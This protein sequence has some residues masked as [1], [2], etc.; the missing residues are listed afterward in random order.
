M[1]WLGKVKNGAKNAGLAVLATMISVEAFS[2]IVVEAGLIHA[3]APSYQ[4][5][6]FTPFRADINPD[7]GLWRYPNATLGHAASCFNVTYQSNSYGARDVERT[8]KADGPRTVVLGDSFVEGIGLNREDRFTEGLERRTGMPHLNFGIV[9]TGPTHYWLTYKH[10]AR[11]FDHDRVIVGILPNN[12]FRDDDFEA[13]KAMTDRYRP[14]FVKD[15]GGG[16]ELIYFDKAN[17]GTGGN[18]EKTRRKTRLRAMR[19]IVTNYSYAKNVWNYFSGLMEQGALGLRDLRGEIRSVN[20][21]RP[22]SGFYDYDAQHL[23]RMLYVLGRIVEDAQGRPVHFVTI[24]LQ[25]DIRRF[26]KEGPPPLVEAL[27]AFAREHNDVEIVDL[28]EPFSAHPRPDSLY[29]PCDG[30]W[31]GA[32]AAFAADV[33]AERIY[34]VTD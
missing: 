25:F 31:N 18:S 19:Q 17:I 16:W 20:D 5:P 27:R 10:L 15:E 21:E 33:L 32:G 4:W 8:R 3:P 22:P 1:S 30:H 11:E 13:G 6:G 7:F 9:N 26:Q 34:S 14:Y 24:P 28:L 2:A 29:L 12:D 23:E